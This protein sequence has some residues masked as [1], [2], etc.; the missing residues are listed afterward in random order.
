M[1]AALPIAGIPRL[2]AN[3]PSLGVGRVEVESSL[4]AVPL[5][6]AAATLPTSPRSAVISFHVHAELE[7]EL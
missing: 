2:T 5:A 7:F 6:I 3:M 1:T 4:H